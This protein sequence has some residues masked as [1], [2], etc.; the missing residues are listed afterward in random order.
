LRNTDPT[1]EP[2]SVLLVDDD[3]FM[4][5][6]LRLSLSARGYLVDEAQTGEECVQIVSQKV[7]DLVLL[8]VNMPGMGGVE[9]CE[10]IRRLRPTLGILMLTV[11]DS[12]ENI[13]AALEAGADDYITKPFRFGELVARMRAVE[14]RIRAE[15]PPPMDVLRT[16]QLEMDL[17]RRTLKKAGQEIRLSP[18]EFNL[19]AYL[20]RRP[21][22]PVSHTKLLRAVWGPEYGR[23]LEYLRTYFKMLRKKIE[24]DP[25]HP[26]YIVT[27]PWLGYRLQ[28][29][30]RPRS[31]EQD[32]A[33]ANT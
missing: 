8:D 21:G 5:H 10:C 9:T 13:V 30:S 26:E 24:D 28:D 11:R 4:R 17:K 12:Q 2:V 29:P 22:V 15:V 6:A 14:R 25:A 20:M 16:G 7:V 3:S 23:E 33:D 18:T 27:E 31:T 19:L 32:S 1:A